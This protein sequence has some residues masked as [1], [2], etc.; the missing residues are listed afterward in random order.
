MCGSVIMRMIFI[1]SHVWFTSVL[2]TCVLCTSVIYARVFKFAIIFLFKIVVRLVIQAFL[3][4]TR[5]IFQ[6]TRCKFRNNFLLPLPLPTSPL[7]RQSRHDWNWS[8]WPIT[9]GTVEVQ[10]SRTGLWA[11]S[12]EQQPFLQNTLLL[13]DK[14]RVWPTSFQPSSFCNFKP[15]GKIPGPDMAP[16]LCGRQILLPCLS[17]RSN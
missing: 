13:N 14:I 16:R 9:R 17:V 8:L 1:W 6:V 15:F 4:F 3:W 7:I 12:I 10:S 5:S 11:L 2:L